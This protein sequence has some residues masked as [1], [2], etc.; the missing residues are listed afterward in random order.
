MA[1]FF[2]ASER[3]SGTASRIDRVACVERPR[4]LERRVRRQPDAAFR[5]GG[6]GRG[7]QLFE[8][9]LAR[10]PR[11]RPHPPGPRVPGG[12]RWPARPVSGS[13]RRTPRMCACADVE[14]LL[15]AY[16][17]AA[18]HSALRRTSASSAS[19]DATR[20][21]STA[22]SCPRPRLEVRGGKLA[23][24][25]RLQL[26]SRMTAA[27][28]LQHR[29]GFVPL[30]RIDQQRRRVVLGLRPAGDPGATIATRRNSC[31]A[32]VTSPAA[33]RASAWR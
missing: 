12:P 21:S 17:S 31:T 8:P 18:C 27:E 4:E 16:S 7:H 3:S 6:A 10:A 32:P 13:A 15:A 19:L 26:V 30:A 28:L 14:S 5:A 25:L 11:R 20:S 29:R 9:V 22:A 2:A 24:H 1:D 33:C 23:R